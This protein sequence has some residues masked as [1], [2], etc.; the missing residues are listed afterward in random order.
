MKLENEYYKPKDLENNMDNLIDAILKQKAMAMD[1]G[2]VDDVIK[3]LFRFPIAA[4]QNESVGTDIL[5]LDIIRGRD[6][7]LATYIDYLKVCTK[8]EIN[9][10]EDLKRYTKEKDVEMLKEI[11]NSIEKIDLIV[12]AIT[13]LPTQGS[14]VG[15]TIQCIIGKFFFFFHYS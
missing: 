2:Y 12:G 6:H 9:N 13:E 8:D 3:H 11:Y 10:W 14:T 5:A 7:G 4:R 1:S 15:P